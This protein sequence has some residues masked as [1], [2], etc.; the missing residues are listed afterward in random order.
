M[1]YSN[2]YKIRYDWPFLA[3]W[4]M[5]EKKAENIT[6]LRKSKKE[7][8]EKRQYI[9]GVCVCVCVCV[10]E[11]RWMH[12]A[13][14]VGSSAGV[15]KIGFLLHFNDEDQSE[16]QSRRRKK[17]KGCLVR[18]WL[19]R[20]RYSEQNEDDKRMGKG[21]ERARERERERE[22]DLA[23]SFPFPIRL[24][25]SFCS[26]ER[27]RER[28]S[29]CVRACTIVFVSSRVRSNNCLYHLG[30]GIRYVSSHL[31]FL[32]P[33]HGRCFSTTRPEAFFQRISGYG[34]GEP[35]KRLKKCVARL[36]SG[37]GIQFICSLIQ[38]RLGSTSISEIK[39][40]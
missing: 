13:V 30:V 32:T 18:N 27:E 10:F 28:E 22:R 6:Q 36:L 7:T 19:D 34:P 8:C 40:V 15:L 12:G 25:S 4:S 26:R 9:C 39:V 5:K 2:P 11:K 3:K 38:L 29:V 35:H 17:I 16:Q 20:E 21:K 14:N 23:L 24:S 31:D 1:G 33:I 37:L